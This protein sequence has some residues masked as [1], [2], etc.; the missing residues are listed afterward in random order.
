MQ[1]AAFGGGNSAAALRTKTHW[2]F[3]FTKLEAM[4]LQFGIAND[5]ARRCLGPLCQR[6]AATRPILRGTMGTIS[7]FNLLFLTESKETGVTSEVD[8]CIESACERRE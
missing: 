8:G 1:G 2:H 6:A 5:N 3:H 7:E 4:L